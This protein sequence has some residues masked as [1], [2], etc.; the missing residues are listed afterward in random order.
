MNFEYKKENK[1]QKITPQLE[2]EIVGKISDTFATYNDARSSNIAKAEALINEIFFKNNYSTYGDKHKTWKSKV[3]MCKLF[4]FYQTLKAFIWKNVY[5]NVNSMFDVSGENHESDS[6]ANRQKA[7]LVDIFEKMDYQKTCDSILDNALLYGEMISFTAWKKQFQEY[8]RPI[9]YFRQKFKD[10]FEKLPLLLEAL[11]KGQNFWTDVRKIYDNPYIYPVNP[12][13]LVFDVTQL[14][15][16]D[17]C[18]K[19]YKSFKTPYEIISNKLYK[20]PKEIAE[21]ITELTVQPAVT[22]LA[23]QSKRKLHKEV[24]NGSTVEVLEHWGDFRM[25]DGTILKNWHAVV[26]ARKFL[27]KFSKN[28][29]IINPFTYGAFV[30]DPETK[31]GISPLYS[32]LDL[33]LTQENLLNRTCDMQSLAE[34]PPILA[35]EGFFDEEEIELYPGKIIEYGDNISPSNL[36]KQLEFNVNVFLN[37]ISFIDDLMSEVS[38]IYPNMVGNNEETSKTATEITTKTQGQLTRLSMML[39]IINQYL[40]IPDVRNV[41][42]LCA[43]FKTGT[44]RVYLNNNNKADI[45]E[46]DDAIRQAEY[47]YTYSDRSAIVEKSQ[48]ADMVAQVIERFAQA[49]P[50]DIPELFTWY[51]EQKGVENPERFLAKDTGAVNNGANQG[52][53]QGVNQGGDGSQNPMQNAVGNVNPQAKAALGAAIAGQIIKPA[54]QNAVK[55]V[56]ND[57]YQANSNPEK[58]GGGGNSSK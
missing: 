47:R 57:F 23:N 28:E 50:L 49:L 51:F 38:G 54:V 46:V 11:A 1:N 45:V 55:K 3:K 29:R 35:P 14:D 34:N 36:F 15:N 39:D 44:E 8:R 2:A 12:A 4:M 9:S 6:Y 31:R 18:P 19:I 53:N 56:S 48:R 32:I 42:K 27:V 26:V 37:D 17:D 24:V 16:W 33:A 21:Q 40:I 10:N 5:S 52:V 25:P 30:V 41:A 20:I 7:V 58:L 13:D 43:D 22:D